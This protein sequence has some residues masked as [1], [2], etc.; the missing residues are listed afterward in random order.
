[1]RR[2][3]INKK[4]LSVAVLAII[5]AVSMYSIAIASESKIVGYEQYVVGEGET[6]WTISK[7]LVGEEVD[8][9]KVVYEIRQKNNITPELQIG[10]KIYVP[11]YK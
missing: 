3:V 8:V 6:L 1:M 7:N 11:V 9:R 4:R 2:F 10:Q 5:A